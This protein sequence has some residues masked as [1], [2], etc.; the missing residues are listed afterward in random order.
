MFA[1]V[2]EIYTYIHDFYTLD[3]PPNQCL[4]GHTGKS[5]SI[6]WF[7]DDSGLVDGCTGG[8]VYFYDL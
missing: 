3:C 8:M 4:K 1:V 5:N 6:D 2:R 7:A